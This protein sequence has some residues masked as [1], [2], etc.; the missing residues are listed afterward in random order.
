MLHVR[1][2]QKGTLLMVVFECL[3]YLCARVVLHVTLVCFL[4]ESESMGISAA[5]EE[6]GR[7]GGGILMLR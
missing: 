3:P 1:T 6:A 4:L 7:E 5:K 2:T